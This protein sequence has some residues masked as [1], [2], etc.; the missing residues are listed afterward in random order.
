MNSAKLEFCHLERPI[1]I[2]E[3]ER[4]WI[5]R[6]FSKAGLLPTERGPYSTQDGS[7]SWK[8]MR[9]ASFALLTGDYFPKNNNNGK[10]K[11]GKN[12]DNNGNGGGGNNNNGNNNRRRS[13]RR[14]SN[15]SS[16][17]NNSNKLMIAR[18]GWS[19]HEHNIINDDT[20]TT[21]T[22]DGTAAA[23]GSSS[24][25]EDWKTKMEMEMEIAPE[26][27]TD[28]DEYD[29]EYCQF[30]PC[31][32]I[33]DG[34]TDNEEGWQYFP[35]F[36]P[37]ALLSPG[38]KRGILDFVRRRK[39]RRIAIFR[40]DHFLPREVYIKCDYCDSNVVDMLSSAMLDA[41]A[42]ATL[43]AHGPKPTITNAQALP[44]KTK[45]IDAL[46]IG[47][48]CND[49][50]HDNNDY[51]PWIDIHKLKDRLCTFAETAVGKPGPVRNL[52]HPDA[53]LLAAMPKRRKV[54]E[55]Y[56]FHEQ[57]RVTLARLIIKDVDRYCFKMHC[58][59]A[60]CACVNGG[61]SS[62]SDDSEG[63]DNNNHITDENNLQQQSSSSSSLSAS[64]S[65]EFRWIPCPNPN[66]QSTFSYKHRTEHD[67]NCQ[68][69]L[70]PCPSECGA[71]LPRCD[72]HVHV[73]D[74]CPLR[75]AECPLS[76]VGCTS[77]VQAR[78][79]STHLNE[80]A[81]KHFLLISSRMMEYQNVMKDMNTRIQRLEEK[82]ALLESELKRMMVNS[83][84]KNEAKAVSND[85]KKLTKRMG[86]LESTCRTEFKKVEYDRRHHK[87]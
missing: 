35:D 74:K 14:S 55:E 13:F 49:D 73:R 42:L 38:R 8:T 29:D 45:L 28:D 70:V 72:V 40:P 56:H 71:T 81:D 33:E 50:S 30:V 46:S 53:D 5:G 79:V 3:N 80:H 58:S 21:T 64:S 86:M 63:N 76:N 32:G 48:N 87:K 9:E 41:L 77:I 83:Q 12:N 65:C 19:F 26:I 39:L 61:S 11:N 4:L 15:S 59:N 24:S 16:N 75:Q 66:C 27:Q 82:N 78:D 43:F 31:K 51:D 84:S 2:Y 54:V 67:N 10:K 1:E 57:E 6:G 85:L 52:F 23:D 60:S 44:L 20:T 37:G 69:K 36:S 68:Y 25:S 7:L 22:T 17:E 62:H 34:I 47:K 18:R